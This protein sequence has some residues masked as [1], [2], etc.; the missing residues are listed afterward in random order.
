MFLGEVFISQSIV[1]QPGAKLTTYT[2]VKKKDERYISALL[3][4]I[5]KETPDHGPVLTMIDLECTILA[6]D[7]METSNQD[8]KRVAHN[9]KWEPDVDL[10]SSQ[11][12]TDLCLLE[13]PSIEEVNISRAFE[14]VAFYY[15]E[16]TLKIV[17]TSEVHNMHPHHQKLWDRMKSLI[18]RVREEKLDKQ[19]A[20]WISAS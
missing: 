18:D 3:L 11:Q 19:S 2:S 1:S 5:D 16:W 12:V 17:A 4:A 6:R 15:L 20:L 14:Q 13:Q 8:M 7:V 10:L 9:F